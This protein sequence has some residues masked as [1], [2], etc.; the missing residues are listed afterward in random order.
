MGA[1]RSAVVVR[2]MSAK[3][4]KESEM[5][6]LLM[7]MCFDCVI[8]GRHTIVNKDYHC[9]DCFLKKEGE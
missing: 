1:K 4:L 8:C 3:K 9:E 5:G 6:E 7:Y 2:D